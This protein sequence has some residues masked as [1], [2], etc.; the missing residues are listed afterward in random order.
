ML[1]T[2]APIEGETLQK[3]SICF[4]TFFLNKE[5]IVD[6]S[7]LL[8]LVDLEIR[9]TLS[10]YE[11]PGDDIPII[12]GS[13]LIALEALKGKP[14]LIR[15]ENNWIDKVYQL[16]DAVDSYIPTPK[17]GTDKPFLIAVEDVF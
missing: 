12:P 13:A 17:R 4:L 9:E 15:G 6:D 1:S 2:K 5:D 16:I 8:E 3:N 7:E 14:N 10:K 11:Y